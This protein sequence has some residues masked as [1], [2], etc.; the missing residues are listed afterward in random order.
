VKNEATTKPPEDTAKEP[1]DRFASVSLSTPAA[2][3]DGLYA[4]GEVIGRRRTAYQ[5]KSG[6]GQRYNIAIA[7][8]GKAGKLVIERWSDNPCPPDIPRVGDRCC[9]PITLQHFTT[10]NGVGTRL[11]W[12]A[13]ERG[14]AF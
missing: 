13:P 3:L 12:G 5:Q 11:C 1:N 7:L 8:V 4:A 6:E 2:K 10:K 9:I 14:E